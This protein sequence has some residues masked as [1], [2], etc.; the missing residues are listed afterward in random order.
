[1]LQD[2][3]PNENATYVVFTSDADDKRSRR[4]QHHEVNVVVPEVPQF[5]HWSERPITWSRDD[6]PAMM[7]SP[8]A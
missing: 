8:S 6:H 3:F 1:M 2:T 7:P 4:Q 5:M